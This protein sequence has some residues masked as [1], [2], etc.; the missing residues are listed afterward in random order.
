MYKYFIAALLGYASGSVMYSYYLPLIFKGVDIIKLSDDHNPGMTNV[1][2]YCGKP[3]GLLCLLLDFLKGFIP[4]YI[5]CG[6]L[7]TAHPLFGLVLASPVLGHAFTPLLRFKGGKAISSAFGSLAA[8]FQVSSIIYGLA[9]PLIFTTFIMTL[10]PHSLCIIIASVTLIITA[11]LTQSSIG[12]ILGTLVIAA[13]LIYKHAINRSR[14]PISIRL[15]MK[16]P[17]FEQKSKE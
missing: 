12:I 13:V 3:M 9:F 6:L 4:V 14:A 15:F 2:I 7:D 10:K 1:M 8:V 5:S 16:I 17:L 11:L